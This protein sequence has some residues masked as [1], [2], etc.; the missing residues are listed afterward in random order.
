MTRRIVPHPGRPGPR[1]PQSVLRRRPAE[2]VFERPPPEVEAAPARSA[3]LKPAT[4]RSPA[5]RPTAAGPT[6]RTAPAVPRQRGSRL[7]APPAAPGRVGGRGLPTPRPVRVHRRFPVAL[8][9]A[10]LVFA[11]LFAVGLGLGAA[12]GFDLSDFFRGPDEPPPRAFPVLEPSRPVSLSIPAIKVSAPIMQVGLAGDGSVDVPPLQKHNEAGWFD[13]GPTPG[14]FGPAIIVG[15]AD[16]RSGPSVFH[17]LKRLKPGQKIS[18]HRRDDSTAIF[19]INSVEHFGKTKL[20]VSRVYGDYSRP[21]L[22]LMTCGGTWLGGSQG[23]EDN[24]VVFA[25]LISADKA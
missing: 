14:Q 5:A 4:E 20:P 24:Y 11:G 2:V 21:E 6:V 9:A 13:E 16:T 17:D 7:P 23:Y 10:A 22:R 15:H 8:I 1:L 12:S 19:E 18:I 25:S 3:E